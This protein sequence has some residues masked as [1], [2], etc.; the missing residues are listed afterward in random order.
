MI[1]I[2]STRYCIGWVFLLLFFS[3]ELLAASKDSTKHQPSTRKFFQQSAV[4][5]TAGMTALSLAWYTDDR[6]TFTWFNDLPEWKQMD[7]AGHAFTSFHLARVY[8]N[9]LL[10]SG[11]SSQRSA[12]TGGLMATVALSSIELLDGFSPDY[13]ASLSDIGANL[14]G[15]TLYLLQHSRDEGLVVS[16]KFSFRPTGIAEQRP[17]V[18]GKNIAEQIL[19]DYNGQTYWLS[20]DMDQFNSFPKWLNLAVGYS[21]MNM[22]YGRDAQNIE[23]GLEPFRR[24]FLGIDIELADI[25]TRH[26]FLKK[27]FS[28]TQVIRIP[29]PALEF[30]NRG[31]RFHPVWF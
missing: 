3:C 26:R 10:K 31:I 27:L 18:L 15:S 29:A 1:K 6:Q 7:K 19:K 25:P 16:P 30:S 20:A 22:K 28:V 14:I 17:E 9:G 8:R 5:Y 12:L 2:N 13:G 4:T 24:W 23:A 11:M 21:A